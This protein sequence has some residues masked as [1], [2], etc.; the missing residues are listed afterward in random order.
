MSLRDG[1][2]EK[3]EA[4]ESRQ[5]ELVARFVGHTGA[6][7]GVDIPPKHQLVLSA[8]ADSTLRL[9][10]TDLKTC[11]N[12]YRCVCCIIVAGSAPCPCQDIPTGMRSNLI[13][14]MPGI[15]PL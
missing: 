11:V 2:E 14:H 12:L 6:V 7:Y 3:A 5:E 4:P 10:H 15:V 1:P 13:T 8:S 9:W